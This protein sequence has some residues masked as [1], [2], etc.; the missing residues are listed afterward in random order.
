[1]NLTRT[2]WEKTA[3]LA[4]RLGERITIESVSET[5][6][7]QGG[8]TRGWTLFAQCFAEVR[9]LSLEGGERID[10]AQE[11]M[12]LSYRITLRAR[13]DITPAMRVLWR[14]KLLNIRAVIPGDATTE[15]I[16][17]EGVAI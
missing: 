14:G 8:V 10:A 1:M 13:T 17:D 9:P 2:G 15:I 12:R 3:Q 7:G 11:V 5:P 16:A 4:S 6:D